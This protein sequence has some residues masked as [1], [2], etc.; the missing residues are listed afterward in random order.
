MQLMRSL[1]YGISPLDPFTYVTVPLV[2]TGLH[3]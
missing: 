1:L 2:L 3:C